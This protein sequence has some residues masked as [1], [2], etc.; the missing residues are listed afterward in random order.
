MNRQMT[1]AEMNDEFGAARTNKKEFLERMDQIIPWGEFVELVQPFYYKGERGNKPYP[2]ELMLRIFILQNLYDLA[3]MKVMNE[4][5]DSRAF[6][7]F[8]CI[9]SPDD[10][11]DG[12]TI[13]RFR[14]LLM[15][16]DLQKKIFD[17]VLNLIAERGLIL[18]KGT[19]V[20]STF[21]EA[22][23]STKN[24]KKERDPE[25][26]SSKKGNTW[27]FGYKAHIG[28]DRESG[29]V[30]HVVTTAANEHDV[31][32]VNQLMHGDEDTLGGDSGYTGAEKRPDAITRNS[33]GKKIK[34]VICRKPSSIRKLSK[35]GQY[36]AKKRE[37]EKSS[38][39]CKV[40]HV[41][42]VVKKLFGYRKT[43][44][45][46]L[47]KQT[48]KNFIMFALANLYLADRKSLSV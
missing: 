23:S 33:K 48:A 38:V 1:L 41:F 24:Q 45:R 44:Y 27:H 28:V 35:S 21:I 13:G 9:S 7:A 42:A 17:A 5:L 4:V 37:H 8:C 16:H 26:H 46:G 6:A 29:L 10:V 39:R 18:K 40:E 25:A 20:D 47:R 22:P 36:A 2:L 19:I 30:H 11:P 43:R 34:Y 12:D 15:E 31:T 14:N 32:V 3:D